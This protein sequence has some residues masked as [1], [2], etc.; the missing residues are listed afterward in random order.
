MSATPDRT[1][2]ERARAAVSRGDWHEAYDL[3]MDADAGGLLAP[4]DFP[5]LGET[6]YA[7]GHLDVTIEVWERAYGER[8]RAGDVVA[9]AGAATRVA[10]HLLFDTALMAPIRGW[11]TRAERLLEG[12]RETPVHAWVAVVRSYERLL[13]GDLPR[14]GE[15]ARRAIDVGSKHAPAAAAIGRVAEARCLI[16]GGRGPARSGATRRSR[17]RHGFR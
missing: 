8:V 4:A 11:L 17:R 3:L 6:A 2:A 16:L 10:M 13:V 5:L 1:P 12:Q 7:A 14:A 15:W 9:A